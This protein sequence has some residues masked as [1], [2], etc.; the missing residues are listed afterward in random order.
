MTKYMLPVELDD[1]ENNCAMCPAVRIH[2]NRDG[3]FTFECYRVPKVLGVR[4]RVPLMYSKDETIPE[5]LHIH[6]AEDCP[7]VEAQ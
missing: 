6:R 5:I 2:D 7:L 4:S 1:G 3:T